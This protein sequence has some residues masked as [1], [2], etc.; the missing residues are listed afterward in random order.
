M[1]KKYTK[2]DGTTAYMFVAYLGVDPL[3]GKQKRAKKQGFKTKRE[4]SIAEAKLQA[5][6]QANGFNSHLNITFDEVA[7]L[8]LEQYKLD[9][10]ESSY[11]VVY[12]MVK[13]EYSK[14]FGK[15]KVRSITS[16][17]CQKI[18][19][20][21]HS[22]YATFRKYKTYAKQILA[23]AVQ[24][25]V[26]NVNPFENVRT[27]R[28]KDTAQTEELLYYTTDELQQFLQYVE[29]EDDLMYSVIFRLLA[30]TG[31]RKGELMALTWRDIDFKTKQLE[32]NKTIAYG[33]H[34]KQIVNPPKTKN[35]N[36]TISIDEKTINYL[37]RWK[38]HQQRELFSHGHKLNQSNQLV[39]SNVITN[40]AL[41][42]MTITKRMN[43]ICE[44]YNF[45]RIRIHGFRHTHCSLLFEAG[46]SVKEVQA[47]L[48]HSDIKTTLDIYT[49]VTEKQR[50]ESAEK[51][52]K[53]V[54]F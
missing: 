11:N 50:E 24:L 44:K 16:I 3:T 28:T 39:F 10:R 47:R 35:S 45:K 25:G 43:G 7:D 21:W 46:L 9:V 13:N 53:Y 48:G 29:Q 41:S 17:Y 2:K 26:I 51:F 20:E 27:P 40:Q 36:R 37:Q 30:F 12:H 22:K 19:N 14:K 6:V 8:W 1:I 49:H 54:N 34:N 23:Y 33:R 4:A 38:L 52:A 31:M 15:M 5:E 42:N 32:I 18:L